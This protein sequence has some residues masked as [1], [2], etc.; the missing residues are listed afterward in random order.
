AKG[1][2]HSALQ[3]F[4]A[5]HPIGRIG[6]ADDVAAVIAFLLSAK[7]DWVTGAIWDVDGGVMAGRNT[8][9]S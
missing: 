8:Y 1:E 2:V 4:N 7:A 5:F 6:T 9:G 3:G